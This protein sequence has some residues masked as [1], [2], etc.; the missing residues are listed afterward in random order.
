MPSPWCRP[1]GSLDL[2]LADPRRQD[3]LKQPSPNQ[4][5]KSGTRSRRNTAAR[6]SRLGTQVRHME[7]CACQSMSNFA[8]FLR[9]L[10]HAIIPLLSASCRGRCQRPVQDRALRLLA[11]GS[12]HA[13]PAQ[14]QEQS[15]DKGT[16]ESYRGCEAWRSQGPEGQE[17]QEHVAHIL[18]RLIL[19]V[20]S[21]QNLGL[22]LQFW[23]AYGW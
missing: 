22:R 6:G 11:T 5:P 21:H 4:A 2:W 15:S 13:Q 1:R 23:T 7:P 18:H 9:P 20:M 12:Q 19:L 16:G 8:F 14:Q 10:A 17:G 3:G